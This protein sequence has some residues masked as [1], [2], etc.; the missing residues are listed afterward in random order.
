MKGRRRTICPRPALPPTARPP[1]RAAP[2]CSQRHQ[3]ADLFERH[4]P[5]PA[6]VLELVDRRRARSRRSGPCGRLG[7]ASLRDHDLLGVH[8][9]RG[10]VQPA[11]VSAVSRSAGGLD[12]IEHPVALLELVHARS[13]NH[14]R[15]VHCHGRRGRGVRRRR[16]GGPDPKGLGERPHVPHP[17]GAEHREAEHT[18]Q[19]GLT[20]VQARQP[21]PKPPVHRLLLTL[22]RRGRTPR[23][24]PAAC[25]TNPYPRRYPP[26]ER[27]RWASR[28]LTRG[29][30]TT[31]ATSWAASTRSPRRWR[32]RPGSSP[33]SVAWSASRSRSWPPTTSG[34]RA[35]PTACDR[36]SARR[37]TCSTS[38]TASST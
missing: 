13:T 18:K 15:H 9:D 12:G 27:T 8:Q 2:T 21:F 14:P 29:S 7:R 36:T 28:S 6:D 34:G 32:R 23:R 22:V 16:G 26:N 33:S 38:S 35:W 37:W 10:Q 31:C 30:R 3:V 1:P 5:D 25:D 19:Q 11:E 20:T 17:P 24:L 4:R